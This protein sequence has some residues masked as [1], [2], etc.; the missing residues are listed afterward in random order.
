[1]KRFIVLF[2]CIMTLSFAASA[3]AEKLVVAHDTNFKPF[4]FKQDGEYVGFDIDLW[5]EVATRSGLDYAF[6][7]MDF[8]GIIPGLQAG[9]IDAA[10]A[11]ITIKPSRQE[12]VDFS[13][14]YYD[15]GLVILVREDNDDIKS[16]E[17]LKGKTVATKLATSSVDFAYKYIAKENVKLFPNNDGMFME[18]LTGGADAVIFDMPVVKDFASKVGKDQTKIVG[19]LYMGQAYGIAFPKGS[20]LVAKVNQALKDIKADGTYEKLYMKWFGYAPAK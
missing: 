18:L 5:K 3:F 2:T 19:P 13:D 15:S 20:P 1:M 10:V 16:V 11:G 14:G 17:D 8:N 7:P 6:Q 4:E 9:S 12:V